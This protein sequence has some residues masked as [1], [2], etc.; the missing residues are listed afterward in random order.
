MKSTHSARLARWLGDE[1]VNDV[2][3]SMRG[4]YGPPIAVHGVPGTV[5]ATG[6]GDF[7]GHV[8]AGFEA[9]VLD[10]AADV[11]RR[12]R[13]SCIARS[14]RYGQVNAFADL[15]SLIAACTGGSATDIRWI[16]TNNVAGGI[17]GG[18][19]AST[20]V[21]QDNPSLP[22]AGV[23]GAAAPGGTAHHKS[24]AG[25][26]SFPDR[27]D[28]T[29]Y[30]GS[31]VFTP[32]PLSAGVITSY[33]LYDRLFSVLKTNS[34]SATEAVTGTFSRYQ[35]S[36]ATDFDYVGG[37]FCFPEVYSPIG[38]T[39]SAAAHNWTVCQYTNQAGTTGKSFQS[40]A[41]G[42][43]FGSAP[44]IDRAS[45]DIRWFMSLA[46]GDCGVK[47]LTQMQCS[48]ASAVYTTQFVV[49]H[50]IAIVPALVSG[51]ICK[52]EGINTALNLTQ[53]YDDACLTYLVRRSPVA[54]G[55]A[56]WYSGTVKVVSE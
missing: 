7:V 18:Y 44:M 46:D 14:T 22:P 2:S 4:W 33:I 29:R 43:S 15:S 16:K 24:D 25:A 30:V 36:T 39:G 17:S 38:S 54:T 23:A 34:S 13:R 8:N 53:I 45:N 31:S 6:D 21:M 20:F 1:V 27:S 10:R 55:S 40:A 56:E 11:V 32:P 49:G 41:G 52:L 26:L 50:V 3:E 37:N 9:S 19:W 35:S 51:E 5:F 28:T 47:S 48:T 12:Y 42:S